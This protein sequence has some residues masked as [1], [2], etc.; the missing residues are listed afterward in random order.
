MAPATFDPWSPI[1]LDEKQVRFV[2]FSTHIRADGTVKP[3]A[4][5]PHPYP[6]LSTT[7]HDGLSER[8]IWQRGETIALQRGK[9]L[10]GRADA[11]S[12]AYLNQGLKIQPDPKEGNPQHVNIIGWPL[13]KP[14]QKIIAQLISNN[15]KFKPPEVIP[16]VNAKNHHGKCV[17]VEGVIFETLKTAKGITLWNFGAS[18]PNQALTA[19][20]HS[21]LAIPTEALSEFLGKRVHL[22]GK[23]ELHKGKPNIQTFSLDQMSRESLSAS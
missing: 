12:G 2:F 19:W 7:R 3:D 13:D 14:A 17:A 4:F 20:A 5:I 11:V 9:S 15:S 21:S 1:S 10:L 8:E 16:C 18:F 6:D 23:V 22:I